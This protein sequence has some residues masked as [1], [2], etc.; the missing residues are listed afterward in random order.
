MPEELNC[1]KLWVQ[2]RAIRAGPA[3]CKPNPSRKS[4]NSSLTSSR[5]KQQTSSA[6][7][8]RLQPAMSRKSR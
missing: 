6:Q 2:V 5:N 8:R 1:E 7:L 3:G 4:R